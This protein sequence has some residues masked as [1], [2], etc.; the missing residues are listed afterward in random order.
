MS[1]TRKLR[2]ALTCRSSLCFSSLR[3][4]LTDLC[5]L[6][7]PTCGD[8]QSDCGQRFRQ[9]MNE[10]LRIMHRVPERH[11]GKFPREP[12]VII[13]LICRNFGVFPRCN[14]DYLKDTRKLMKL[15]SPKQGY[16]TLL[17]TFKAAKEGH[18]GV[19]SNRILD[20]LG[21][22][23]YD[24]FKTIRMALAGAQLGQ[25]AFRTNTSLLML[26]SAMG[27]LKVVEEL[28]AKGESVNTQNK[29]GR[30]ALMF[31]A[32]EGHPEVVKTL[33]EA[34]AD[35]NLNDKDGDTAASLAK[36]NGC[37]DVV[38][39]LEQASMKKKIKKK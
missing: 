32:S 12:Q 17:G 22:S 36:K 13:R 38:K 15:M 25:A 18:K 39:V 37:Y 16:I 14:E 20:I 28:L 34:G 1:V 3:D 7:G 5:N 33:S 8:P 21:R 35:P 2:L 4:E 26:A 10:V 31:A 29:T 27:D 19:T 23:P 30:T 11:T 24:K 9:D 6:Y